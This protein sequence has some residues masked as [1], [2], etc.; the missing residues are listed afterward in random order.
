M[1]IVELGDREVNTIMLIQAKEDI[2]SCINDKNR[3]KMHCKTTLA[4]GWS[5]EEM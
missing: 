2:V 3:T 1:L 4:K 5:K